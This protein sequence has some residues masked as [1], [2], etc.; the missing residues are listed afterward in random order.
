M[1]ERAINI[2]P[3]TNKMISIS[4][5]DIIQWIKS[6]LNKDIGRIEELADGS[7]YC[8]LFNQLFPG[9]ISSSKIK[10]SP[11][12]EAEAL[13]NYKLLVHAFR[14]LDVRKD[15]PME[16]LV[17]GV[18]SENFRFGQWFKLFYDANTPHKRCLQSAKQLKCEPP[19]YAQRPMSVRSRG[20][21]NVPGNNGAV[22]ICKDNRLPPQSPTPSA[23][24]QSNNIHKYEVSSTAHRNTRPPTESTLGMPK[25]KESHP[26]CAIS[27]EVSDEQNEVMSKE[28]YGDSSTKKGGLSSLHRMSATARMFSP[29]PSPSHD[30]GTLMNDQ[31]AG[32]V[33]NRGSP[34][35][36]PQPQRRSTVAY[37]PLHPSAQLPPPSPCQSNQYSAISSRWTRKPTAL[38][39]WKTSQLSVNTMASGDLPVGS[40]SPDGSV[41]ENNYC[42]RRTNEEDRKMQR[43]PIQKNHRTQ[44]YSYE[45]LNRDGAMSNPFTFMFNKT[46]PPINQKSNTTLTVAPTS[47]SV[48]TGTQARPAAHFSQTSAYPHDVHL[49]EMLLENVVKESELQRQLS[50]MRF[51]IFEQRRALFFCQ[52]EAEFY[53]NKLT[54]I[55]D[56]CY[57]LK[58]AGD[59][60]QQAMLDNVL[61]IL[62]ETEEG[63]LRPEELEP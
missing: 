57:Q 37:S 24:C 19:S 48:D 15:V 35:S 10:C 12:T 33:P 49:K 17:K 39:P 51:G 25:S 20:E 5:R 31:P 41:A 16:G 6:A 13:A 4:R 43:S 58:Q 14:D 2:H 1:V 56:F 18:F 44:S 29:K 11:R 62:Y 22:P 63:H 54:K 38:H 3:V 23:Y 59:K 52:K 45:E 46:T 40:A 47:N 7:I 53:F 55:E 42:H 61:G 36:F 32:P 26:S 60:P 34:Q 50:L 8:L 27:D 30:S 9:S 21:G 28:F